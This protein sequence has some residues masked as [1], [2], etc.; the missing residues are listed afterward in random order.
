MSSRACRGRL[1]REEWYPA[2][3]AS[4]KELL[5]QNIIAQTGDPGLSVKRSSRSPRVVAIFAVIIAL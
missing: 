4:G 3:N 5:E 2:L 1:L